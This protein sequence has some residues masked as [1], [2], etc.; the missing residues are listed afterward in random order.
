MIL[1]VLLI[2]V[3]VVFVFFDGWLSNKNIVFFGILLWIGL[4]FLVVIFNF[5]IF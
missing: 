2:S 5:F 3:F 4:V 1:L